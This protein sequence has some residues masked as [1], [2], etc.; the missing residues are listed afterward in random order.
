MSLSPAARRQHP[1]VGQLSWGPFGV[2][3][4]LVPFALE[5]RQCELL[6]RTSDIVVALLG[7]LVDRPICAV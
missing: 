4:E 1:F 7:Q 6:K 3:Q 5:D 2:T